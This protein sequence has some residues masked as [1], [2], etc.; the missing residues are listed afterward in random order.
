MTETEWLTGEDP[1]A[2]ID[3][4]AEAN[5]RPPWRLYRLAACGCARL[6]WDLMPDA[7][8]AVVQ[9][10][11]RYAGGQITGPELKA[12]ADAALAELE[13]HPGDEADPR[14]AAL[15]AGWRCGMSRTH[16]GHGHAGGILYVVLAV[17]DAFRW[18]AKVAGD[19]PEDAARRA[20]VLQCQLIRDVFGNPFV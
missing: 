20:D 17:A 9:A 2:L 10:T 19:D 15:R 6:V 5:R 13:S 12:V 8:R 1:G 4:L 16:R 11:E 3:G 14:V 18:A 7:G